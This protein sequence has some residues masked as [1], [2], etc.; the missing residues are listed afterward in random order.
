MPQ[1]L[2]SASLVESVRFNQTVILPNALQGLF[3]PRPGAVGAATR[4]NVVG[5]AVR[6]M[7]GLR[8]KYAPGPLWIR[9]MADR[10]LLMLEVDQVR[11]VLEGS[12]HPFASDPEAKR[13]GMGHFQPD[14]LTLSRGDLWENR[15]GFTETVL[16]TSKPD[17]FVAVA[18]EEVATLLEEEKG[19]AFDYDMLHLA[20]RRLVRRIVLGDTARDD[21]E[22]SEMLADMMAKANGLPGEPSERLGPLLQRIGSYVERAEPGSLVS[23][24]GEAP[25]DA[26]TRVEGQIQHWL[27]AM[28]DTLCANAL[29]A[30]ALLA[31]HPAQRERAVGDERYLRACLEE[32]MRLWPT[33]PMLSRETLVE[34][35]WDGEVLPPGTQALIVNNF[36]HRD[37]ERLDYAD[38]FAP[39]AWT[40]GDAGE[41]WGFNHFSHG[42]QGCPGA[43][44]ALL[45]GT[46]V[47]D[48]LLTRR[49]LRLVE[50]KLD[51]SARS[52]TCSTCS[53]CGSPWRTPDRVARNGRFARR[54]RPRGV[55]GSAQR[56]G[57]GRL[58]DAHGPCRGAAGG[59][60]GRP[61]PPCRARVDGVRPRTR[62]RGACGWGEAGP[63][64]APRA[65]RQG[66][67][68]RD[69]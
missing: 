65:R 3:R 48:E 29:R 24:F 56:R 12:P 42:P 23:R 64:H 62:A 25:S 27:F 46:C 43:S 8:R 60:R 45:L 50:P 15:R 58:G 52:R 6:L 36:H 31:T 4:L 32:A 5:Q 30:L 37:P 66:G 38:R 18:R 9:V 16:D 22:L 33:T 49:D 19:S 7:T 68:L 17:H 20:F 47:L 57:D 26:D 51:R 39:E 10:A 59:A 44:L 54:S 34:L 1:G 35:R 55:A 53:G 28:Q 21:E 69:L 61:R 40:E 2:P 63:L 13:K 41:D 11:R 67:G 14:A